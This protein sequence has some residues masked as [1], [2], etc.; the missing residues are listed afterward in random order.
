VTKVVF[1]WKGFTQ[2]RQQQ[3]LTASAQSYSPEHSASPAKQPGEGRSAAYTLQRWRLRQSWEDKPEL[4]NSKF[5]ISFRKNN[6]SSPLGN[7]SLAFFTFKGKSQMSKESG[8][9]VKKTPVMS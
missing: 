1:F 5:H 4:L 2:L 6:S 8:K 9:E 3:L 7:K